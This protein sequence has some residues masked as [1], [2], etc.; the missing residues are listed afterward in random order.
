MESN[1]KLD[2]ID[3]ENIILECENED[4]KY[5]PPE[6][7]ISNTGQNLYAYVTYVLLENVHIA[8]AIVLA[9]SLINTGCNC[10][11]VVMV[12]SN[13]SQGGKNI[14]QL[15]YNQVIDV[16]VL[17]FND[18][19]K[20]TV[21]NKYINLLLTKFYAFNLTQ[22]KKI[23]LIAPNSVVLKHSMHVFNLPTPAGI[24]GASKDVILNTDWYKKTCNRY[25]HGHLL[26]KDLTDKVL[27]DYE[28]HCI[29]GN[30]L[31]LA[32]EL[33]LF[34]DIL[35]DINSGK[36]QDILDKLVYPDIQYLTIK[37]SGKW[38]HINPKFYSDNG[39]PHWKTLFGTRLYILNLSKQYKFD[40]MSMLL[41]EIYKQI[42][43]IYPELLNNVILKDYNQF[44]EE[45]KTLQ[46]T[47]KEKIGR[48]TTP[49]NYLSDSYQDYYAMYNIK[50][51]YQNQKIH[52]Y[53]SSYYHLDRFNSYNSL[54]PNV[55]FPDIQELDYIKPIT[56]LSKY[57]GENNYY[58]QIL[59]FLSFTT[60]KALYKY[61]YLEPHI[62]DLVMLEYCKCR[63]FMYVI[64]L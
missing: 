7:L 1:N 37:Y 46:R 64:M 36:Y 39:E 2:D 58:Q 57:F 9:Q 47:Q 28:N 48:Q 20:N 49:I 30:Y 15:F 42:I 29:N 60:K 44:T 51:T 18:L 35:L 50:Q 52:R 62:R 63:E 3:L 10:D 27:E 8:E 16:N 24:F 56:E 59:S 54:N 25:Q 22:Y 14:L 38:T 21:H 13:I 6:K 17:G 12:D 33:G 19:V 53:Q 34:D 40:D 11:R 45:H 61:N 41:I 26:S 4:I 31:L 23:L 43:N 5:L 55:M 32:P